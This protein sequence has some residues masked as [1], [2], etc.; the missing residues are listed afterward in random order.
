MPCHWLVKGTKEYCTR[1]TKN[2]YCGMHAFAINRRGATPPSACLLCG[3][4]TN[5]VTQICIHCGQHK[6][7]AKLWRERNANVVAKNTMRLTCPRCGKVFPEKAKMQALE[8]HLN[9]KI[10][11]RPQAGQQ[12]T[13]QPAAQQSVQQAAPQ[14][15]AQPTSQVTQPATQ[16]VPPAAQENI[17]KKCKECI[18]EKK[19]VSI[20]TQTDDIGDISQ[21]RKNVEMQN[22][23]TIIPIQ[24]VQKRQV[25]ES[26]KPFLIYK[27]DNNAYDLFD[28][29]TIWNGSN[30][31]FRELSQKYSFIP[32]KRN[33]TL[34]EAYARITAESEEL[35]KKSNGEINMRITGNYP[36]TTLELFRTKSKAANHKKIIGNEESEWIMKASTGG[37]IWAEQYEGP[38]Q[39]LDYESM[40]PTCMSKSNTQWP[41]YEGDFEYLEKLDNLSF[42]IYHVDIEG[43]PEKK[44]DAKCTR[45]FRYN[46]EKYYTH[47]DIQRARDLGLEV[48]LIN[49]SPNALIYNEKKCM[50]GEDL[51]SKWYNTLIKIKREGG[52]AGK[53]SKELLVSLWGVLCEQRNNRFYGPHPRIKPFL[54]SLV[55]KTI[56]ESVEKFGNK[57]KRIHT[58]GFVISGNDNINPEYIRV[59]GLE[60]KKKGNCIVKNCNNVKWA[61]QSIK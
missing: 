55:R 47:Y 25:T 60:I 16:T 3:N 35:M 49:E 42:G 41:I 5:S 38:A 28:G 34:E 22:K 57:V 15:A 37:I 51:F 18:V 43:Q 33:E 17:C 31:V 32:V 56:S 6:F 46:P 4:G 24:L 14:F 29:K 48:K 39:E 50:T 1:P 44:K 30:T 11:C 45:L 53:A 59:N 54:L 27:S 40:Y 13:P 12:A 52:Y 58:D 8:R 61:N 36:K 10:P 21:T 26:E 23:E 9:R 19:Y 20:G 2:E 7:R